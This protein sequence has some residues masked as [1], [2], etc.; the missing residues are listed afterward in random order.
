MFQT[1][2]LII[3]PLA[4]EDYEDLVD[5]YSQ[6][7]LVRFID[8]QIRSPELT[9]R[10]L[11]SYIADHRRYGFGLYALMLRATNQM[12]G[13]GGLLPGETPAGL[14]GELVYLFREAYWGQGLATEF[15]RA[16]I[17]YGFE[18]F[19]LVRIFAV[20]EHANFASTQVLKKVGM[21]RV[22]ATD[23]EQEYEIYPS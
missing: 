14:Q 6:I 22:S 13:R 19:P 9:A 8:G 21:H 20:V 2:R 1:D 15:C 16:M 7:N 4:E 18:K 23:T 3:R 17:T 12:I 5:L 11:Q 10:Y